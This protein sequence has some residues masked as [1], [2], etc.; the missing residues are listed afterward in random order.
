MKLIA[1]TFQSKS[2]KMCTALVLDTGYTSKVLSWDRYL[3]AEL[4]DVPVSTLNQLFEKIIL[5][6]D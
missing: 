6:E 5:K 1:K 3:I 4:L 2:G